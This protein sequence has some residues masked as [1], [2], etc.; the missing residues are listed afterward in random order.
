MHLPSSNIAAWPEYAQ[1]STGGPRFPVYPVVD[2]SPTA[3]GN[4]GTGYAPLVLGQ[5]VIDRYGFEYLFVR[6]Q[7]AF[8]KGQWATIGANPAEGAVQATDATADNIHIVKTN[9]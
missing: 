9:H 7:A 6:A 4:V 2:Q 3:Q 8:A 5:P 1:E